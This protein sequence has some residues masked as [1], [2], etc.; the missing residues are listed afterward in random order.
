MLV[1]PVVRHT[2]SVRA[3]RSSL[4]VFIDASA[5]MELDRSAH[6]AAP[7]IAA[8]STSRLARRVAM[9]RHVSRCR[10]RLEPGAPEQPAKRWPTLT[11]DGAVC[12]AGRRAAREDAAHAA[13]R[14]VNEL[15]LDTLP[16]PVPKTGSI[17]RDL[18]ASLDRQACPERSAQADRVAAADPAVDLLTSAQSPRNKGDHFVA[19]AARLRDSACRW[20][21]H[22]LD[23]RGRLGTTPFEHGCGRR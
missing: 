7:Q 6:E 9:Q 14:A 13:Y 10:R 21:I 11:A 18:W 2:K 1:G 3:T 20:Q 12:E 19:A 16:T 17:L 23:L 15:P 4:C 8:C 22:F 5:S